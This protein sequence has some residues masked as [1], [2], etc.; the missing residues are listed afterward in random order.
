M[1]TV[2]STS[3]TTKSSTT[4]EDDRSETRDS[5]YFPGCRKDANCNCDIC[6]ASINATLDLMPMSSRTKL[7][8]SKPIS[9]RS[10]VSFN[11]SFLSTPRRINHQITASPPLKSTAKSSPLEKLKKKKK[12]RTWVGF[13][14]WRFFLGMSLI[15]AADSG[16]FWVVSGIVRPTLSPETVR[17]V[18]EE[19][20]VV[21]DLNG[22]LG[23]LQKKLGEIVDGKD[24]LLLNSRCTL[25]K[26]AGEE[27]SIRGWPL[28]TAGL[29]A[30]G[31]SSRSFTVL[32]GSVTEWSEGKVGFSVR[33]AYNSWV[34]RKWSAS[35]V[36]MDPN[37]WLLEYRR[38]P[39]LENSRLF[40]AAMELL[41]FRISRTVGE[42]KQ[43]FWL[44][45]QKCVKRRQL[46]AFNGHKDIAAGRAL[47]KY[48]HNN[49]TQI[50]YESK[51]EGGNDRRQVEKRNPTLSSF[52]R[53]G[54]LRV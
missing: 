9:K 16:F 8:A 19:S 24:G 54:N 33:K 39:I 26:S 25:Y 1:K 13:N 3:S 32:S 14:L 47:M 29:L 27:V 37:T 40:L 5:C 15:F 49:N 51:A 6:L 46:L 17:K 41:K 53:F 21:Q 38:S 2:V 50:S 52:I 22:R 30:S 23:F 42:V 7:S 20:W 18:G 43:Q 28:Q 12:K 36:Q 44:K 35:A 34:Q 45:I 10:P 4:M 11:P 31:F 48:A